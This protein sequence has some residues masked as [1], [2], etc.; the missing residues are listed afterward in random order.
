MIDLLLREAHR[1]QLCL[2]FKDI[3]LDVA[4]DPIWTLL[5]NLLV[6]KRRLPP[7]ALP[8]EFSLIQIILVDVYE[9]VDGTEV[10]NLLL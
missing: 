1:K 2:I 3:L 4:V 10:L 5:V 7:D 8:L 9:E 6:V